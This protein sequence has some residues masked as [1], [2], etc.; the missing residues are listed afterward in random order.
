MSS[1]NTRPQTDKEMSKEN[2]ENKQPMD[3]GQSRQDEM[4][5]PVPVAPEERQKREEER[6]EMAEDQT[7]KNKYDAEAAMKKQNECCHKSGDQSQQMQGMA[8]D[9]TQCGQ[10]GMD[11]D[12]CR[13]GK[14][15]TPIYAQPASQFQGQG[16][17]GQQMQGQQMQGQMM[18]GQQMQGQ[19]D[20]Q[21]QD[22]DRQM[23][24][25]DKK[26][27]SQGQSESRDQMQDNQ[28]AQTQ[29]Y[30]QSRMQ[31]DQQTRMQGDQQSQQNQWSQPRKDDQS[32]DYE[33][34]TREESRQMQGEPRKMEGQDK[35]Q[36]MDTQ[37]SR[38]QMSGNNMQRQDNRHDMRQD[39]SR[40]QQREQTE[41]MD[42]SKVSHPLYPRASP[43][44]ADGVAWVFYDKKTFAKYYY[45]LPELAAKDV[46]IRSMYAGL[47]HTDPT[48]GRS[49]WEPQMYPMCPG[50]EIIG[51]V[52]AIGK[53][54]KSVK[55]GDVVAFGP[56]RDSCM[57][58][59][60]CLA[61]DTEICRGLK[62]EE[63]FV[64][65]KYFGGFA[66]HQQHPESHC[67]KLPSDLNVATAAP[68][69]C[70]GATV[71]HP[72]AEHLKKGEKIAVFG[73]GG[74]GH[75]AI[76]YGVK[77]GLSVDAL[78]HADFRDK[79]SFCKKV[80][81]SQVHFWRGKKCLEE[82]EETYDAI[83]HTTSIALDVAMMDALLKTLKPRGKLILLGLPPNSEPFQMTYHSAIIGEYRIF[84]S[85]CA[86]RK[87]TEQML[88]YSADKEIEVVCEHFNFEDFPKALDRVEN[89]QPKFRCVIDADNFTKTFPKRV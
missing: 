42:F 4:R 20:R 34:K 40:G 83:V 89:A 79:E 84:A 31:G 35:D 15:K 60:S 45:K 62:Q 1:P 29:G 72:M 33:S 5:K 76:Q 65:G 70:A 11:K 56:I 54:V 9:Q 57:K 68:L 28:Q 69:M 51:E 22:K 36:S 32:R 19:Q 81:V 23:E 87:V 2:Q 18:Q 85:C 8:K 14:L 30:Q 88:K 52:T 64:Y 78:E 17:Q 13:E 6:R 86:G 75:L 74:L 41:Q 48:E 16:Q 43:Q 77:M 21:M 67:F 39:Q 49:L 63:R 10:M 24:S 55:I 71:Y 25:K 47:C 37:A 38:D 73:I 59:L 58:C 53:E 80:G 26:E 44:D 7:L 3:Q 27:W 66:S 61:G 12:E 82:L 46:R 50:H